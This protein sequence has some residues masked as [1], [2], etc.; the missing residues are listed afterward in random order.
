VQSVVAVDRGRVIGASFTGVRIFDVS[1]SLLR[2]VAFGLP[3]AL[4]LSSGRSTDG[5]YLAI[6]ACGSLVARAAH[7][8]RPPSRMVIVDIDEGTVSTVAGD[9]ENFCYPPV[10]ARQSPWVFFGVPFENKVLAYSLEDPE[11]VEVDLP[12]RRAP[13]PLLDLG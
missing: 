7:P 3:S 2:H 10:F 6:D 4:L 11:I 8:Q 12:V 1:G 13:M 5:R 9:F